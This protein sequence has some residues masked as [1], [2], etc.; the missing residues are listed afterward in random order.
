MKTIGTKLKNAAALLANNGVDWF[1]SIILHVLV[2]VYNKLNVPRLYEGGNVLPDRFM[3]WLEQIIK[4][5][6]ISMNDPRP[7]PRFLFF[8]SHWNSFILN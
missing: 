6:E 8:F 4:D 2:E 3:E 7:A 5:I 1:L